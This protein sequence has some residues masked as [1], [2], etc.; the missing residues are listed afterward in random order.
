MNNEEQKPCYDGEPGTNVKCIIITLILAIGY[1]YLPPKNKWVLLAI[2]Y[3]TYLAIAWYDHLLCD[4]QFKPTY[5]KMFYQYFKPQ[6]SPQVIQY[7]NM[8]PK[9]AKRI[10]TVDVIILIIL[11]LLTPSFLSWNPVK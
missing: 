5:L 3:L 6:D 2:L 10:F 7:K 8:C 1:W 11:L 4:T 9:V